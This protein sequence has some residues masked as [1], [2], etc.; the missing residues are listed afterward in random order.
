M[1]NLIEKTWFLGLGVL[2]LTRDKV[3]EAVDELVQTGKVEAEESRELIDELM[4][5]GK[6][7]QAELRALVDREVKKL[8]GKVAPISR[9]D[10]DALKQEVADL[11]ARLEDIEGA[12]S[13]EDT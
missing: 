8:H 2:T 10:F 5:K 12:S 9:G 1:T 13:S 11:R 6:A 4:E 3:T 7:E